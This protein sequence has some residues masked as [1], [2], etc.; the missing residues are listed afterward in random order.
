MFRHS[1]ALSSFRVP[2][3]AGNRVR[4]AASM[5]HGDATRQARHRLRRGLSADRH[6]GRAVSARDQCRSVPPERT[7]SGIDIPAGRQQ[8]K[9]RRNG[10]RASAAESELNRKMTAKRQSARPLRTDKPHYVNPRSPFPSDESP[11]GSPDIVRPHSWRRPNDKDSSGIRDVIY[12][13]RHPPRS[14]SLCDRV[15]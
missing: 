1:D 10:G 3:G 5:R 2:T 11:P 15:G 14:G 13:I 12:P 4:R 7:S 9:T 8:K 6:H